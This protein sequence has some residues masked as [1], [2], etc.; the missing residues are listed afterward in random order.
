MENGNQEIR[1]NFCEVEPE[2]K[3]KVHRSIAWVRDWYTER[4]K[5]KQKE[6]FSLVGKAD[7]L[8]V[9]LRMAKTWVCANQGGAECIKEAL[10]QGELSVMASNDK[11]AA[12]GL[13]PK[14]KIV[15]EALFDKVFTLGDD[16]MGSYYPIFNAPV[17]IINTRLFHQRQ[18]E[19]YP[20]FVE[21][22]LIHELTHGLERTVDERTAGAMVNQVDS[23]LDSGAEI[24]A[25]L[26]E[27]RAHYRIDPT[28]MVTLD[29]ITK[30]RQTAKEQIEAYNKALSELDKDKTHEKGSLDSTLFKELPKIIVIDKVLSRYSDDEL[31][32]LFNETSMIRKPDDLNRE[33]ALAMDQDAGKRPDKRLG[34]GS[35][36]KESLSRENQ[37][38][39]TGYLRRS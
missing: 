29:D 23:Y 33:H 32:I 15:D 17:V 25:R 37:L 39:R 14:G 24:Y 16:T 22:T 9:N 3:E 30:M 21:D 6:G 19:G 1:G 27:V 10:R 38:S 2:W 18:A 26:N 11:L 12:C 31:I 35:S 4:A 28:K 13:S 20:V 36:V 5:Y 7:I 8:R 34:F